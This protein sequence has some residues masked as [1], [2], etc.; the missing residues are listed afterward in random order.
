MQKW[1]CGGEEASLEGTLGSSLVAQQA[2]DPALSLRWCGFDSWSGSFCML[3]V[4]QKKKK[5][6]GDIKSSKLKISFGMALFVL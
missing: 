6:F 1:Q 4:H 5:C 2:K 3:W